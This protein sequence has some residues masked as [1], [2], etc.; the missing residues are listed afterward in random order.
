MSSKKYEIN[1]TSGPLLGKILLF[2]IPLMLSSL[3]QLLFNAA[4][5][6]VVGRFAGSMA[7]AAV[8]S[9]SALINLLTNLFMGLSVGANVLF[10]RYIGSNQQ[11][12]AKDL[13]H[14]SITISIL[15]GIILTIIGLLFS[16]PLLQWMG[17]PEDVI[18]L[19]SV[20]MKIYFLGM[21]AMLFYNFGSAILR[22][23]GDTRRPLIF[24]TISGFI[25]VILNIIFVTQF[26]MSVAGVAL[27]TIISQF[28][29]A[30]LL[31]YC[32]IRSD[33]ACRLEVKNLTLNMR[34]L[35]KI[36]SIGLPAGLQGVIFSLSNVLIQSSVNSFGAIAV[37]GNSAAANIEGFVW[38]SMNALHQ[39]AISFTSQNYGAREF[40]RVHKTLICCQFLVILT[41]LGMGNAAYLFGNKLLSFYNSDPEVI[42]YG[43]VRMKYICVLYFTCGVMDT[44]VGSI[45]GLGYSFMPTIVSL[46]GACALRIVWIATIFRYFHT[47]E[48]LYISYPVSWVLT[49]SIHFIC[50]MLA[51]KKLFKDQLITDYT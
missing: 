13:M 43:L 26:H 2:A 3:L 44:F 4:D 51:T 7:L 22:A 12:E 46:L 27:A 31:F 9:T 48:S 41:G 40:K 19:A 28:I 23:V 21:P 34:H 11:K 25:N 14:T 39:S 8:G 17:T 10:A 6:I 15:S 50:Y 20:Y 29:S 38:V 37:A 18:D 1:M 24:L 45:R 5:V 49:L 42:A 33:G 30:C 16:H 32:M 35:Q 36:V 47:L